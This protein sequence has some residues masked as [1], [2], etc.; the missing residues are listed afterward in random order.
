MKPFGGWHDFALD[1]MFDYGDYCDVPSKHH[2]TQCGDKEDRQ[3]LCSCPGYSRYLCINI[4]ST[5]EVMVEPVMLMKLAPASV[6][7]AFA[8]RVLPVPG[9]PNSSTPLQGCPA[10]FNFKIS[11]ETRAL[12]VVHSDSRMT[13]T[14]N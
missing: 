6:A 10:I 8:S 14:V 11:K 5:F 2:N 4:Q 12:R 7:T 1:W 3:W 13:V 9:G